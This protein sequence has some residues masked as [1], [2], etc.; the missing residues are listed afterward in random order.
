MPNDP[1]QLQDMLMYHPLQIEAALRLG[2]EHELAEL[3]AAWEVRHTRLG[4]SY[5]VILSCDAWNR[6]EWIND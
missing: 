4:C 6:I 3:N 2:L 1:A 5:P